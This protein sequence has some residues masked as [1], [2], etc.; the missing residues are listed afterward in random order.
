MR[1]RGGT[2]FAIL[3][4]LVGVGLVAYP[5]ISDIAHRM[6]EE[7]KIAAYDVKM[8]E[9]PKEDLSAELH[10]AQ[11]YNDRLRTARGMVTDPFDPSAATGV[12]SEEYTRMLDL[13]KDGIMGTLTIPKANIAVAIH[14]GTTPEVLSEG[15]GHMATTSLP[16]GGPSTHCVLAGHNGM[17]SMRVFDDLDK[18]EVGDYFVVSVLGEDH[19]YKVY[20]IETV[21]PE[22]TSSLQIEKNRDLMTLVTCVPYGINTHRLLVHA[23]RTELP[24]DWNAQKQG[25]GQVVQS[26]INRA[27]VPA[28][29]LMSAVGLEI[30]ILLLAKRRRKDEKDSKP[31]IPRAKL[32]G[33]SAYTA[34]SDNPYIRAL[35][36]T[37]KPD[38]A[39]T[40]K[41]LSSEAKDLVQSRGIGFGTV[42]S[43]RLS[44][45]SWPA[46]SN[47]DAVPPSDVPDS[48]VQDAS[49]KILSPLP[50][51][52]RKKT[53]TKW[54]DKNEPKA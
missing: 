28:V 20:A 42:L 21:L 53:D 2:L 24:A 14:H 26:S 3:A 25:A 52:P 7:Q 16:V 19:A 6:L 35:G 40:R 31:E 45:F 5:Y 34:E 41:K 15:V 43:T 29:L 51:R 48:K 47:A 13:N 10:E 33:S 4:L 36:E 39:Q 46:K 27:L 32:V 17:P 38:T 49:P 54:D 8:A 44:K 30:L 50:V 18:L 1:G 23:E 22:E 9:A 12:S 11:D 37:S